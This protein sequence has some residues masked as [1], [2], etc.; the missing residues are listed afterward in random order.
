FFG[1]V[2]SVEMQDG[3]PGFKGFQ[4]VPSS[5]VLNRPVHVA[6]WTVVGLCGSIAKDVT[7]PLSGPNGVHKF[8]P[9]KRIPA[10]EAR[11][12]IASSPMSLPESFRL[13]FARI[14]PL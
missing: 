1:S 3:G 8:G 6:A 13:I 7:A 5:E 14:L 2:T 4:V 9:A 12:P 11:M 10:I